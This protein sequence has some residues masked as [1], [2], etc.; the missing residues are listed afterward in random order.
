[1]KRVLFV[2]LLVAILVTSA[3]AQP[4]KDSEL[5]VI[6]TLDALS[7]VF[8]AN[9]DGTYTLTLEAVG[10][11]MP[12]LFES[13]EEDSGVIATESLLNAWSSD[14]SLVATGAILESETAVVILNLSLPVYDPLSGTVS[15]EVEI[16]EIIAEDTANP[17]EVFDEATLFIFVDEPL[18]TG[19][20]AAFE[21]LGLRSDEEPCRNCPINPEA[22]S[23]N[24]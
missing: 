7:G 16:E 13:P 12:Y 14:E 15:Y 17:P 11:T 19:F 22:I 24:S 21:S 3:I 18:W 6:M 2:L 4:N 1:M 5:S 23:R 10:E 9:D 8:N 20:A